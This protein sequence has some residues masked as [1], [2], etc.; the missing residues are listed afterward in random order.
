[1]R[2]LFGTDG[3]RGKANSYPMIPELVLRIA[4]ASSLYFYESG[5]IKSKKIIIAKDTRASGYMLESALCAGFTSMGLDVELAGVLPTPALSYVTANSDA[6]F[7]VMISAS[8]NPYQDNGIKFFKGSGK[9]FTDKEQNEITEIYYS[10]KFKD[11][12]TEPGKVFNN[13]KKYIKTYKS[14]FDDFYKKGNILSGLNIVVDTSNGACY[15]IAPEILEELGASV[16]TINNTPNGFNINKNCGSEHTEEL[17]RAVIENKADF[18]LAFDGDGDRLIAVDNNGEKTTGDQILAI[19][20]ESFNEK[21]IVATIMSN[22][23]F[24]KFCEEKKISLIMTKVG[25]RYVYES[26]IKENANLGGEDSGHLIFLKYQNTGDGL[27]SGVILSEIIKNSNKP[28]SELKKIITIYPQK[29]VNIEVNEKVPVEN[30]P[31]IKN[32]INTIEKRLDKT[33]RVLVRYSGTQ[34]MLRIM[35]EASTMELA[36]KSCEFIEKAVRNTIA[37]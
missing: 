35:C 28:L 15:E 16:I 25:D 21:K 13:H 8:H 14:L 23:G 11:F 34:N 29:L 7:S 30:I 10:K 24:K 22:L 26:M 37:L 31:E 33:G 12:E 1:M 6:D 9:K 5:R 27:L 19:A 2:K 18:G 32:A 36:E 4:K 17:S 3:I 20:S